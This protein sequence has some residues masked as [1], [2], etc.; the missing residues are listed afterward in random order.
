M[1]KVSKNIRVAI[2]DNHQSI[3][4]GYQ[5]RLGKDPKIEVVATTTFGV[6]LIP[7]IVNHPIDVL[8]LDLQVDTA[9]DDS[10]PYPVPFTIAELHTKYPELAILVISSFRQP[11]FIK[12]VMKAGASGYIFKDDQSSILELCNIVHAIAAGGIH[13]SQEAYHQTYKKIPSNSFLTPRQ[14]QALSLCAAYPGA[15][16]I[17]LACLFG[18]KNSTFRNLLSTA[19]ARLGVKNRISAINIAHQLGLISIPDDPS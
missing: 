11:P 18:V 10:S 9:S 5:Y 7:M 4:D 17:E 14:L 13:L 19:Y 3:I 6:E 1:D 15:T 16:S 8:I 12:I 2:L